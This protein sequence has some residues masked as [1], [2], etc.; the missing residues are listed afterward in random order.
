MCALFVELQTDYDVFLSHGKV[1]VDAATLRSRERERLIAR[2]VEDV[3]C[4]RIPFPLKRYFIEPSQV[5]AWFGKLRAL[6]LALS[7]APFTVHGYYAPGMPEGVLVPRGRDAESIAQRL[8]FFGEPSAPGWL[9][10]CM[11]VCNPD[12][13]TV[14]GCAFAPVVTVRGCAFAPVVTAGYLS[15][16]FDEDHHLYA[17]LTDFFT[18]DALVNS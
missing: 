16:P 6:P 5:D 15:I 4:G 13:A 14:S 8:S 1:Y 7:T 18:E 3:H 10:S 11:G 17:A 12:G 9:M 2:V